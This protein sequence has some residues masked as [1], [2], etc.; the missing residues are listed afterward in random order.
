MRRRVVDIWTRMRRDVFNIE[1]IEEKLVEYTNL[2]GE[3]GAW[4]RNAERWGFDTY[5]PDFYNM[6]VF[7]ELRLAIMDQ[8]IEAIAREENESIPFLAATQYEGKSTPIVF[9]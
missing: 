9:E 1:T 4:A 6:I 2:L 3:S 7:T 8:A 5:Y